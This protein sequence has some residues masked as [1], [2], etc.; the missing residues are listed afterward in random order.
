MKLDGIV[1][2]VLV[3][4]AGS[5]GV[6]ACGDSGSGDASGGANTGGQSTGG[7]NAGGTSSGGASTGGTNS[8]GAGT[9]ATGTGGSLTDGGLDATTKPDADSGTCLT[10]SIV[11]ASVPP[12]GGSACSFTFDGSYAPGSINLLLTPGWGTVCYAG[13]SGGCGSGA[14][15][16]G[17]WWISGTEIALCDS[18]CTRFY[19]QPAG[20]LTIQLGCPT[21]N[22]Y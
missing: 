15:S 2:C 4:M 12:G 6:E 3:V 8:G 22:C 10:D 5:G 18:T 9:G 13:S 20:K 21:K 7:T 14:S 17:W 19:D 1:G 11:I 16:D